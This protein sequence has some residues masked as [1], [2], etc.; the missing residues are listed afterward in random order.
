MYFLIQHKSL[1]TPACW[2]FFVKADSPREGYEYVAKY[3]V[4]KYGITIAPERIGELFSVKYSYLAFE[5][6]EIPPN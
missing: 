4:R 5:V 3:L 6:I 2:Y 1:S